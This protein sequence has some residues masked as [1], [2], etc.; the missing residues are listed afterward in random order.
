M[1]ALPVEDEPENAP[2]AA[3][4][5][6][7]ATLTIIEPDD[8]AAVP[9]RD[10]RPAKNPGPPAPFKDP[11]A[12]IPV[13]R[14]GQPPVPA[15]LT[16]P[17]PEEESASDAPPWVAG[18]FDIAR[19]ANDG[20]NQPEETFSLVDLDDEAATHSLLAAEETKPL[21]APRPPRREPARPMPPSSASWATG[22]LVVWDR[23][24]RRLTRRLGLF[25]WLLRSAAGRVFLGTLGLVCWIVSLAWLIRDW[26]Q[27]TR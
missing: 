25:G 21:P 18:I 4:S 7:A 5:A 23:G 17:V 24:F 2:P 13:V 27:W 1:L 15:K 10:L 8:E 20:S 3:A 9:P 19:E 22:T 26:L 16:P 12:E 6:L 11:A 14:N